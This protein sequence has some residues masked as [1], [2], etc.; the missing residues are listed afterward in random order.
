MSKLMIINYLIVLC[1]ARAV[2]VYGIQFWVVNLKKLKNKIYDID[3]RKN[4]LKREFWWPLYGEVLDSL[5]IF[6]IYELGILTIAQHISALELLIYVFAHVFIVEPLYYWYHRLLHLRVLYKKHHIYHHWSVITSPTTSF[7]FTF[8]ERISY[9]FIFA[10]PLICAGLFGYSSLFGMFI[11]I[12][13]F[14]FCNSIGHLNYEIFPKRYGNSKMRFLFYTPSFHSQH[15][16]QFHYNYSLFMPIYDKIFKTYFMDS[17]KIFY[18]A[19]EK[20]PQKHPKN[21]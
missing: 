15:H 20:L 21:N 19:C 6:L 17:D 18:R 14:D 8:L 5:F 12:I 9:S 11:Y 10:I 13:V 3:F 1:F 4:Q 2:C 16:T 7:T